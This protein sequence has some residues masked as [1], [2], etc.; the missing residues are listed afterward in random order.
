MI[1]QIA[2]GLFM[3]GFIYGSLGEAIFTAITDWNN[4]TGDYK[5]K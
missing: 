2:L 5:K 4:G 3:I 1:I